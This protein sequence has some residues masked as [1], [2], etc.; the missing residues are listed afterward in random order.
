MRAVNR[1]LTGRCWAP[2][3]KL[4]RTTKYCWCFFTFH[5]VIFNAKFKQIG[6]F[7]HSF[8]V[9]LSC[10]CCMRLT[11][12]VLCRVTTTGLTSYEQI[13]YNSAD[14]SCP[15]E[16]SLL[17]CGVDNV[18]GSYGY[19]YRTAVPISQI[20]CYCNTFN[21]NIQCIARCTN[22]VQ[23]FEIVQSPE[24]SGNEIVSASCPSGKQVISRWMIFGIVAECVK[25]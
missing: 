4:L 1:P 19:V 16:L 24:S 18:V 9:T 6:Q 20:A 8:S 15:A 12:A 22:A 7:S 11:S 23:G 13:I 14:I 21:I 5:F 2:E 10:R 3:Q 25:A 17:S